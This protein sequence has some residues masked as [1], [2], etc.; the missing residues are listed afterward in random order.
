MKNPTFY[1]FYNSIIP[2]VTLFIG[3]ILH[4]WFVKSQESTKLLQTLRLEAYADFFRGIVNFA[5]NDV[6]NEDKMIEDRILIEN[7]HLRMILYGNE[8]VIQET[9]KYWR[10][11]QSGML[12]YDKSTLME[13][14]KQIE[15]Q[16]I[17]KFIPIL[18]T[19]RRTDF[20]IKKNAPK[21][22]IKLLLLWGDLLDEGKLP[23]F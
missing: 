7:A 4:H 17:E 11:F 9:A 6:K 18:E 15:S 13:D 14:K 12:R 1:L 21:N 22:D 10:S 2:I 8:K 5:L 23:E 20:K 3:A 19:I 16:V